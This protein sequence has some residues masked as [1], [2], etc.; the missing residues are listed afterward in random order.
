MKSY[1]GMTEADWK[2]IQ[3]AVQKMEITGKEAP[4]ITNLMKKIS[5]EIELLDLPSNERPKVG[6]II[7]KE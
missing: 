3:I 6:D 2:I 7:T 5:L 1:E 4:I